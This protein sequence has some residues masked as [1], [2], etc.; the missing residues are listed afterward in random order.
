MLDWNARTTTHPTRK[1]RT[2]S[3]YVLHSIMIEIYFKT[4]D[5]LFGYTR[6]WVCII[7]LHTA[8]GT[9]PL[10]AVTGGC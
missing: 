3:C 10:V 9:A 1:R 8:Y 6:F 5:L 2:S 7:L 4:D